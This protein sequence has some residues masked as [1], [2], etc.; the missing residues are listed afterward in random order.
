MTMPRTT[1]PATSTATATVPEREGPPLL[2][3]NTHTQL[4][5]T[6]AHSTGR[7]NCRTYDRP[8]VWWRPAWHGF[9]QCRR[10][11]CS[12]LHTCSQHWQSNWKRSGLSFH[13]QTN[14]ALLH[15]LVQCDAHT[16]ARFTQS[17]ACSVCIVR[18]Y[19]DNSTYSPHV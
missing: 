15:R 5:C 1:A 16:C 18:R 4:H 12:E 7:L 9:G 3:D 6:R 10:I 19:E 2:T 8:A 14:V 13:V 17:S 11:K